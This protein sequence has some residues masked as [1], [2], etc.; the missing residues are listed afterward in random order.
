VDQ[1]SQQDW[2]TL[3]GLGLFALIAIACAVFMAVSGVSQGLALTGA[4]MVLAAGQIA[5]LVALGRPR[6]VAEGSRETQNARMLRSMAE[7]MQSLDSRLAAVESQ[8]A[9]PPGLLESIAAEVRSLRD[10][11]GGLVQQEQALAAEPS[12]LPQSFSEEPLPQKLEANERIEL[13]LEP[14]IELS[15]GATL[16]YR[17]L[18]SLT[19]DQG[20]CFAHVQLMNKAEEGGMREILDN[21]TLKLVAPVLRRLRVRNPGMRIF[22]SLG[23]TTLG[24]ATGTSRLMAVL[25]HERDIA[26]GIVFE[27]SQ[28][29]LAALDNTGIESLAQLGRLGTTMALSNVAVAGVDLPALRHLGVKFLSIAAA[30]FDAGFGAASAWR[31]FTQ[32]AR[33]MQFQIIATGIQSAQ[34]ASASTS[35]VRFGCGP[36][37]APPRK[38]KTDAGVS[39]GQRQASAA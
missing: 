5:I 25:E 16:H 14:V 3:A 18:L 34:Q 4:I 28:E 15:S 36:F 32:Y 35:V 38:V 29:T 22:V 30:A 6:Q 1:R 12:A 26:S 7:T 33:A 9:H 17:A 19:D 2:P 8:P 11:I 24:S 23:G 27:I 20:N 13:L 10:S 21:H 31:D 39:P 37:F